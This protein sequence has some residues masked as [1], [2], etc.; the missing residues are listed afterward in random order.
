MIEI[1]RVEDENNDSYDEVL[2]KAE[3]KYLKFG[4][5][6]NKYEATLIDEGGYE[7]IKGYGKSTI[8]AINDM[9]NNLI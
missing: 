6:Q 1:T 7:I 4:R 9:H 5:V 3:L 2:I 8:E